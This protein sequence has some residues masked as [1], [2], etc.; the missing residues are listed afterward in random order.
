[1][2]R[3]SDDFLDNYESLD[4][5]WGLRLEITPE[6]RPIAADVTL[7]VVVRRRHTRHTTKFQESAKRADAWCPESLLET[8]GGGSREIQVL[9]R[10]GY[11][12]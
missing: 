3:L 4:T 10:V 8:T 12:G 2:V 6:I 7:G 9:L 1:M 11:H 5:F